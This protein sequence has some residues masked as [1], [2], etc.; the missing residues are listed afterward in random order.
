MPS[1]YFTML[2]AEQRRLHLLGIL[3]FDDVQE[4]DRLDYLMQ[5]CRISKYLAGRILNGYLTRDSLIIY[6]VAKALDVDFVWLMTGAAERYHP[7]T[8]R[9]HLQQVNHYPKE[10]TDQ[11]LRLMVGVCAGHPK[12]QNLANLAIE[13]K[14]SMLS[15]ARLM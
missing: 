11:M 12:S 2:T 13:G 7:R 10:A 15:A 9:I 6:G 3:D 4:D 1:D 14:I 8:L 5:T